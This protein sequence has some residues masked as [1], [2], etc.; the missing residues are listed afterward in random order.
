MTTTH[1]NPIPTPAEVTATLDTLSAD[2]VNAPTLTFTKREF[3]GYYVNYQGLCL[4]WIVKTSAGW[5]TWTYSDATNLGTDHVDTAST[6]QLA[7]DY[8]AFDL[9]NGTAT[10]YHFEN[11]MTERYESEQ[12]Y[13]DLIG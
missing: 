6:R 8:L 12:R 11:A 1:T 5:A 3:G 9:R 2:L 10:R 7:A 4:G 13:L